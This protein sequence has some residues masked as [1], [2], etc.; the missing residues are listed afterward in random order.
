M[1]L[2]DQTTLHAAHDSGIPA[3]DVAAQ[4]R[5]LADKF[6]ALTV[7]VLGETQARALMAAIEGL[8]ALENPS[9]IAALWSP[10]AL[11]RQAAE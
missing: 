11:S 3:P 1:R 9:S 6:L 4:G 7:P 10:P 5:R 8:E 2:K